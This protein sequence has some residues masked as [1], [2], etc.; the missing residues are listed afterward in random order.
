MDIYMVAEARPGPERGYKWIAILLLPHQRSAERTELVFDEKRQLSNVMSIFYG[1]PLLW[2]SLPSLAHQN[3]DYLLNL[4]VLC[5]APFFL[6]V[7]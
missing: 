6:S 7:I 1:N 2:N 3:T 4:E 5:K